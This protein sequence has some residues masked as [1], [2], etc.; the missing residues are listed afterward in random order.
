MRPT[1]L[2]PGSILAP[3]LLHR[4]HLEILE[5]ILSEALP[6]LIWISLCLRACLYIRKGGISN[7]A[8]RRLMPST[9]RIWTLRESGAE[10]Q[11]VSVTRARDPL[12]TLLFSLASCNLGCSS[13]F[14]FTIG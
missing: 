11:Y 1:L 8:S 7:F 5:K 3:S 13:L 4:G 10:I 12:Q 14:R 6:C 9:F 2:K